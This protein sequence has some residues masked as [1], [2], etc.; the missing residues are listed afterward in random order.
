MPY[1][2]HEDANAFYEDSSFTPPQPLMLL[3]PNNLA[4]LGVYVSRSL[5]YSPWVGA[6]AGAAIGGVVLAIID[7]QQHPQTPPFSK[8]THSHN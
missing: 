3:S 2:Q 1:Q 6:V 5:G 7:H 4:M 8:S